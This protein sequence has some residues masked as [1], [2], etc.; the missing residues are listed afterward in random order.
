MAGG[1]GHMSRTHKSISQ[2]ELTGFWGWGAPLI[3]GGAIR[4]AP[5]IVGGAIRGSALI[6][7]IAGASGA[8]SETFSCITGASGAGAGSKTMWRFVSD[9]SMRERGPLTFVLNPPPSP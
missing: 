6:A 1:A 7:Y 8:G 5:L 4:G 3:V 9:T 2:G